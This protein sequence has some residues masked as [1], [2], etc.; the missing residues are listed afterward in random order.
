MSG[1][2]DTAYAKLYKSWQEDPEAFWA[3]AAQAIDW[4]QAPDHVFDAKAGAYGA[5][6]RGG[7]LQ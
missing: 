2:E 7:D 3:Q 4:Y 5:L 6:V 1:I